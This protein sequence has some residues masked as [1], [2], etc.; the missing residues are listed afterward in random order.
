MTPFSLKLSAIAL[1][2]GLA[3]FSGA[4]AS[5]LPTLD[6]AVAAA[7]TDAAQIEQA[8]MHHG[9]RHKMHHGMRHHGHHGMRHHGMRGHHGMRHH[10]HH[11][12]MAHPNKTM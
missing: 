1:A 9:M 4:P 5:A 6:P 8:M 10:G 2:F 3:A 12:M 7:S 11:R